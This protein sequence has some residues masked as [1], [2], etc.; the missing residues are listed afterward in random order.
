MTK[1]E[2]A[3]IK[4]SIFIKCNFWFKCFLR[5]HLI[6]CLGNHSVRL[7]GTLA[8]RIIR[9]MF[10]NHLTGDPRYRQAYLEEIGGWNL[11]SDGEDFV[12]L[13]LYSFEKIT[14]Y[15]SVYFS[16][17]K[18]SSIHLSHYERISKSCCC[19][20]FINLDSCIMI[21]HRWM[22]LQVLKEL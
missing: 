6:C 20:S 22:N 13:L 15:R 10:H 21:K 7:A 8:L 9:P 4:N 11:H 19:F 3:W 17:L 5:N 16:S 14:N 2:T 18:N 1:K 12:M